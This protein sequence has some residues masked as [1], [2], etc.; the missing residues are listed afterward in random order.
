MKRLSVLLMFGVVCVCPAQRENREWFRSPVKGIGVNMWAPEWYPDSIVRFD[1]EKLA[2]SL[3]NAGAQVAFTFQGFS[4][5]HFGISYFPTRLGPMHKNLRGRDNLRDYIESLHK[6]NIKILGYYS[7]PDKAVWDRN[8]DWRQVGADGKEMR[9]GNFGGPLCPNSPYHEHYVARVTEIAEKYDLDGFMLDG[10]SF[11]AAPGC[12]CRYCERKFRERYGRGMPRQRTGYEEDW[13]GFLQF[14]FDCMQEFY[15]DVYNAFRKVRPRML[16][17]HNAFDLRG[18]AWGGGEDYERTLVLDDIV[19]SIGSWGGSIGDE[20]VRNVDLIWKTGFLTRYL[21]GISDKAVWMQMGAYMYNRDYQALPVHELKLAAYSIITNGG[22][23]V[24]ITNTFP[25]G[26]VDQVLS[27]RMAAVFQDVAAKREYLEDTGE[28][29]FAALYFSR[30]SQIFTDSAAPEERRYLSSFEGAYKA[31][32]EEHIPFRIIGRAA[33]TPK[34]LGAYKVLILPDTAVLDDA[35]SRAIEDFVQKGGALIATA[36]T[37]LIDGHGKHRSNFAL[38]KL[39][40]ADYVN[41]VNYHTSFIKSTK[42]SICEGIDPRESIPHRNGQQVK[43]RAHPGAETA[44]HVMLPATEVVP[45]VRPFSF[46]TDVA[47]GPVSD[48]PAALASGTGSGRVVYFAGDISGIY[49]KYGYPSLRK[50]LANAVR[51]G[52]GGKLPLEVKA[53]LA[54]EARCFRQGSRHLVHL[55]NYITSQLRMSRSG[56]PAAEEVI[57]VN[58]ISIRL[59]TGGRMPQRVFLASNKQELK[60]QMNEGSVLVTVPRID[61]HDIVVFE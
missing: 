9:S 61:V 23:P 55:M 37:S 44:A 31:L 51:W 29:D 54:V 17:T 20:P 30:E 4:Q 5:D 22:S 7:F 26:T 11:S 53:P 58:D 24:Y 12:Y 52:A 42:H 28:L 13:R 60:H 47:P 59:D 6:R 21:K 34:R 2:E 19:T 49:G 45:A 38:A 15:Q 40:R 3:A 10:A 39:Y 32:T 8:P 36:R 56:G 14:R 43:V 35:Q 27:E 57:P 48:W 16:Y 1:A 41:P 46:S 33:L 18:P 50:L 25:D